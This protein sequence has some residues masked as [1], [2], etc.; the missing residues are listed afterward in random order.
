MREEGG[1]IVG[2]VGEEEEG[3]CFGGAA[4]ERDNSRLRGRGWRVSGGRGSS[5]CARGRLRALEGRKEKW[6]LLRWFRRLDGSV[7]CTDRIEM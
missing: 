3:R 5:I 2:A 1:V 4:L 6:G 7:S